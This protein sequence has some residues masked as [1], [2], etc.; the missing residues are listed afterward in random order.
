MT[1]ILKQ[2][3][4]NFLL[5]RNVLKY[6]I[7]LSYKILVVRFV[8]FN[9]IYCY[10]Y[11]SILHAIEITVWSKTFMHQR[12]MWEETIKYKG[13]FRKP[14]GTNYYKDMFH[15]TLFLKLFAREHFSQWIANYWKIVLNTILLLLLHVQIFVELLC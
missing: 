15:F 14:Y 4:K 11:Y 8:Q 1:Y 7:N 9:I 10:F 5:F 3:F 2:I 6:A 13:L 12:Q